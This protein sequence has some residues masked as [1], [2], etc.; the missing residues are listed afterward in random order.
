MLWV[1][2]AQSSKG[3]TKETSALE[4]GLEV[5]VKTKKE[6]EREMART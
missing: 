5:G 1:K 4:S 2:S 3:D 6:R